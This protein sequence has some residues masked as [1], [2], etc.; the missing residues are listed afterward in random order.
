MPPDRSPRGGHA[1]A[2]AIVAGSLA[3]AAFLTPL[4]APEPDRA[5][6]LL[7]LG[8]FAIELVHAFRRR[9]PGEQQNAW[10][11]AGLTLLVALVLLNTVMAGRDRR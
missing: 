3:L 4:W 1:P 6:G 5:S 7:L 10:A 2:P 8:G 11:S 9:T